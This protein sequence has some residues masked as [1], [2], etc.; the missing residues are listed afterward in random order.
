MKHIIGIIA[1]LIIIKH[2]MASPQL[3]GYVN[4][5]QDLILAIALTIASRPLLKRIFE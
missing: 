2:A 4:H 3:M 5:N 1:L